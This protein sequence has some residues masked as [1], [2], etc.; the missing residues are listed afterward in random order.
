MIPKIKLYLN[1]ET[2]EGVFGSGKWQLL[3]AIRKY[4]SIRNASKSLDRSYRKAWGDIKLAEKGFGKKI[5]IT[6]RGGTSGGESSLT[7][8]GLQLLEKWDAYYS[9]VRHSMDI[10]YE[11][12]L[13]WLDLPDIA[14]SP[15]NTT[16]KREPLK[17]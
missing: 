16:A 8:F 1:S 4:G 10:A 7:E 14:E 11:N 2:A 15:V 9:E 3:S 12:H 13:Q 5:I 6:N 17:S